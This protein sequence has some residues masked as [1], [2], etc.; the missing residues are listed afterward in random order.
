ME[1]LQYIALGIPFAIYAIATLGIVA[2][3]GAVIGKPWIPLLLYL[4]IFFSFPSSSYGSLS[5]GSLPIYQR[6]TGFLFY[7]AVLWV[8]LVA[9]AWSW[10][11]RK[12][13][14]VQPAAPTSILKWFVA[15][16]ILLGVHFAWGMFAGK[17]VHDILGLHGFATIPW[18][19][20][21]IL[22]MVW[23]GQSPGILVNFCR[24]VVVAT[25][26][27]ASYGIV[28]YVFLGGDP[29]NAY[30]NLQRI[31]VKLTFFDIGDGLLCVLGLAI[32]A[33]LLLIRRDEQ[34]SRIW[35]LIYSATAAAA[36]VSIVFS[37]RRT[38]W[39]GLVLASALV[40]WRMK[41]RI[42]WMVAFTMMPIVG[43]GVA[44]AAVQRLGQTRQARGLSGF[45][46]DLTS[47]RFGGET[48]RVLELRFAWESFT[49][50][51]LFGIGSW[52]RYAYGHLIPW[53]DPS[54][55]GSFLHSGVLHIALKTGLPGL[56]LFCGV[57]LAFVSRVRSLPKDMP[58][59]AA[60][61]VLAGCCG[62]LF[63]V[64]DMIIGTPIPQ[65]RT[66]QLLALCLGLP[67]LVAAAL[68]NR[69]AR[70]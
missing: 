11:G 67:F 46:Y 61:L 49:G 21:L 60:A 8:L 5:A 52:G 4:A 38:A 63:M 26:A 32:S 39:I 20:V 31:N 68:G 30:Q 40:L 37:Y 19:G 66:S 33:S 41:P 44:Y 42:R 9:V 15:W 14:A 3:G 36:F 57:I 35:D 62:L 23:A 18:M 27:R 43:A 55:P 45:V 10:L 65:V 50:S 25:L 24:F 6:G 17:D 13:G 34:R 51:P 1:A 56:V 70:T 28:R 12:L 7:P 64:P 29:A 59:H 22:L 48:D 53:Q 69:Q 2:F 54:D 16:L 47:S 58:A